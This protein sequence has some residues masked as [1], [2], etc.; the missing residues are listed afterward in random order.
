MA[1]TVLL[2]GGYGVFG[3]RLSRLLAGEPGLRLVVAGRSL[4]RAQR[5]CM[6]HGGVPFAFDRDGD[7]RKQLEALAPAIVIDAAGPFQ[8][9]GS[10]AYRLARA[11]LAAGAHYL[12]LADDADFVFGIGTLDE[13]A[14]ATGRVAISGAS[15]VPA[16]SSAAADALVGG[17]SRVTLIESVI[18]PGNRA[19]RGLSVVRAVLSQVGKPIHLWRG[20]EW[21]TAPG[22]S[23]LRRIDLQVA[24]ADAIEGR[25]CAVIGAPDLVMFPP[26]YGARSVLFRAGLELLV[27]HLGLWLASWAP[28]LGIVRSLEPFAEPMGWIARRTLRFGSDR[29]GM[30]VTVVGRDAAGQPVRRTWSLVVEADDGPFVPAIPGYLLTR[31]ILNDCP[32]SGARP[33]VGELTLGEIEEGLTRL[34]ATTQRAEAPAPTLYERILGRDHERLPAVIR[35]LHDVH[36]RESYVGQATVV[37]GHSWFA[38]LYARLLRL[39]KDADR[40]PVCV[41]IERYGDGE[42]W[43]RQ[44]GARVFCSRMRCPRDGT[45][46]VI[47]EQIGPLSLRMRLPVDGQG[48]SMPIERADLFGLR[49]PSWL[50]PIGHTRETVDS[51]GRFWFDVDVALPSVGRIIRYAGWLVPSGKQTAQ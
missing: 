21:T 43:T 3:G 31:K 51:V 42:R 39:P 45:P 25:W 16:I 27:L 48:L 33:C 9:Y 15:S 18:L 8:S 28:R 20:G 26:R 13:L 36:D 49:L 2:V 22:W 24:G 11:A 17:L 30:I 35:E 29:G 44:F 46:G 4:E 5:F 37:S 12:D 32:L 38:R 41:T 7:L 14:K 47:V 1:K 34:S 23:A 50:T 6:A 40:V 10:D 19:P